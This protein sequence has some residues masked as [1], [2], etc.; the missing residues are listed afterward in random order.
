MALTRR[1]SRRALLRG[2][3]AIA[4]GGAAA[5]LAACGDTPPAASES[6]LTATGTPLAQSATATP[7][8]EPGSEVRAREPFRLVQP[9][10]TT[11]AGAAT[12]IALPPELVRERDGRL[13]NVSGH[14]FG[15]V[16]L[17][18]SQ[19][20]T[21][22]FALSLVPY[23]D[24]L[25]GGVVRDGIPPI[26]EPKFVAPADADAWLAGREPVIALSLAGEQRAYPLQILT[27]H[28]IV[29]D[30]VG[31][32]PV[33]VTFCPL[34]NSSVV[35]D[36]EV[37]GA[38]LRFGVSGNLHNSDLIMWDNLTESWWQQLT[39][40]GIVG[41]LAGVR[42][43]ALPSQLI[44]YDEFKA[45]F[46]QGLV[47]SRDTG[48]ARR[49]GLNPYA[50]YDT[51][52]Q[53]PFLFRGEP[54]GRL[55]ATARVLAL[56]VEGLDVAYPFERLASETVVND[57]IA[58]VPVVALWTPETASALGHPVIAQARSVGSAVAFGRSLDGRELTFEPADGGF[59]DRQT[60]STWNVAGQAIAGELRGRQLP[61]IVH[62]NHFWFAWAAFKPGTEIRAAP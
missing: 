14:E 48:F 16:E 21:T 32:R 1:T 7:D 4:L 24:I 8:A 60:G 13:V 23:E 33:A 31:G 25:S 44:A 43:Q 11:I 10:S 57:V 39:G 30:V 53:T 58:G 20:W 17:W 22:N 26:D 41:E 29:N 6:L 47:L 38:I 36:R 56:S 34:C 45:A 9:P 5:A 61:P 35:F 40:E 27:R 52:D 19:G 62:A 46:P 49:Y 28:E 37:F 15:V 51:I 54:D 12:T 3:G 2:A 55:R 59:R 42:L 18:K 50:G